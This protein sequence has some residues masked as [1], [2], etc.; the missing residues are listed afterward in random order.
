MFPRNVFIT[1]SKGNTFLFQ[2][3]SHIIQ[4]LRHKQILHGTSFC[5][6]FVCTIM[7]QATSY[8]N[9]RY[10]CKWQLLSSKRVQ[11]PLFPASLLSVLCFPLSF[12]PYPIFPSK[13]GLREYET[14]ILIIRP[15]FL[16]FKI[17]PLKPSGYCTYC[18]V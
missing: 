8:R 18:Q 13:Q 17:N 1:K 2:T 10:I 5:R 11:F 3:A 7:L 15:H 16:N 9:S 6:G 12:S 4:R 14:R